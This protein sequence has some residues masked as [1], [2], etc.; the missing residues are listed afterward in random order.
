VGLSATRG[1]ALTAHLPALRALPGYEVTALSASSPESARASAEALGIPHACEDAAQLAGH[2][3]VDLVVI[4]VKVPE[5]RAIITTAIEAGK[6]VLCEWP[7]A[8]NVSEAAQLTE[9]ARARGI[10]GFVGLQARATPAVRYVRDLVADGTIGEVLTST[11][12]GFGDRWGPTIPPEVIYLL[13][14]SNGATMLTIPVAHTLDGVCVCL[15]ELTDVT[16]TTAIRRVSANRTDT[17]EPVPMQTEDAIAITGRLVSGA[18]LAVHY[19]GGT[20]PG[21]GLRWTITGTEGTLELSGPTGHLQYGRVDIARGPAG[22]GGLEP[23]TVPA[24]YELAP[25]APGRLDHAV[26]NAYALLARDLHEGTAHVPTFADA[27]A[28]H[29]T[30]AAIE[31]AAAGGIRRSISSPHPEEGS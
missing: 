12:V 9:L 29:R 2:D 13:D 8:G 18:V 31:D 1:W 17:G 22:D 6:D 26:A 27:L 7:L 5:H 30:V 28:R 15:G 4:T 14:P 21:A 25:V 3:A 10:Q 11:V 23:V 19:T 20:S 16:A 24:A